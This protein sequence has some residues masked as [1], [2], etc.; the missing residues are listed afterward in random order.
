MSAGKSGY[1]SEDYATARRRF[2]EAATALGAALYELRPRARAPDGNPLSIDIAWFGAPFPARALVHSSGLHGVEGFAGSAIQLALMERSIDTPLDGAVLLVHA[3]NPYGMAWLRRFNEN[4][5]D[6]NRNFGVDGTEPPET[7]AAY[8]RLNGLLNP[9]GPP[10]FD[11][12]HARAAYYVLRYGLKNLKQGVAEGQY[13]FPRGLF[14]GGTELELGPSL[15]QDWLAAQLK[16]LQLGIAIDVHTGLGRSGQESLFL[17]SGPIDDERL[18]A[19]L[20]P[21]LAGDAAENGVGYDVR[22]GYAHC[23]DRLPARAR[24]Y[25]VTQEFGTYPPLKVLHALRQENRWHHFGDGTLTHPTKTRLKEMFAPAAREWRETV[26]E[27]GVSLG[28]AAAGYVF[29]HEIRGYNS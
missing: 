21:S 14:F 4:N 13:E 12:F 8:R 5:V 24:M 22:G 19:R 6:L 27:Y 29:D 16:S 9:A 18:T 10:S 7:S 17:R 23:F 3:L 2:L 15:Y 28:V 11:L 20:G 25:A 26:V 1:F